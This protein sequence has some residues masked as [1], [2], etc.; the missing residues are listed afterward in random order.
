MLVFASCEESDLFTD[1]PRDAFIGDWS[2]TEENTL[3]STDHYNVSISNSNSD[4]TAVLIRNF[5]AISYDVSV[6]ATV[7]GSRITIPSQTVS[8]FT[9]QGYG[10]MPFNGKTISWSYTV[11]YNNGFT[12]SVTATYTKEN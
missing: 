5:Y 11:D 9:I 10:S 1:D 4:T 8:G 3:K 2:V 12:D 6:E 7:S